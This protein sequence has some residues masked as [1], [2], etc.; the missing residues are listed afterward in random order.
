M[1]SALKSALNKTISNYISTSIKDLEQNKKYKI[2]KFYKGNTK[3]GESISLVLDNPSDKPLKCYL[4]K[5]YCYEVTDEMIKDYQPL[6][7][8][9]I[10]KG[11]NKN[12]NAFILE[13]D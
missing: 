1:A 3:F 10:Y 13:F 9:L 8:S 2:I 4:P 7:L 11:V 12:N 6:S 5:S